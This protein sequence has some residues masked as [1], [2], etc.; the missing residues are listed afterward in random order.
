MIWIIPQ[1]S[2][3]LYATVMRPVNYPVTA[4][5]LIIVCGI[6]AHPVSACTVCHS[7]DPKM[8]RMHE[9]LEFKDCFVCHGP[10]AKKSNDEPKKQMLTDERCVKCHKK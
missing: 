5:L 3:E 4:V 6:F 1:R 9:A 10:A 7:K 8:V 2:V